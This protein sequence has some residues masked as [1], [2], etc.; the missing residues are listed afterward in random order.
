M[1][2]KERI[3]VLKDLKQLANKALESNKR[4]NNVVEGWMKSTVEKNIFSLKETI[5]DL[6]RD[7][8]PEKIKK[9][10]DFWNSYEEIQANTEDS[11]EFLSKFESLDQELLNQ[12]V[13][14][15]IQGDISRH[16][17]FTTIMYDLDGVIHGTVGELNEISFGIESPSVLSKYVPNAIRDLEE[18]FKKTTIEIFDISI[19][20]EVIEESLLLSQK[21]SYISSNLLILPVLE[22][23]CIDLIRFV[24]HKQNPNVAF[25]EI[26]N[27]LR[28]KYESVRKM[29]FKLKLD[30]DYPVTYISAISDY[31]FS[32]HP[33]IIEM[34]K[35]AR[36]HK[37]ANRE[38]KTL[39]ANL[40]SVLEN[41]E[42]NGRDENVIEEYYRVY[43][44]SIGS[45]KEKL[46]DLDK[47][48]YLP[49]NEKLNFVGRKIYDDRNRILHGQLDPSESS[50]KNYMYIIGL[51]KLIKIISEYQN[52]YK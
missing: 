7:L 15:A 20:K 31:S 49:L 24:Y 6:N 21:E 23:L 10:T 19:Y 40:P 51:N 13:P 45:I 44:K 27:I 43:N 36:L 46:L 25:D 1:N 12:V 22:G 37:K 4:F 5:K 39:L 50:W 48:K 33:T 8:K 47:P 11:S 14:F 16:T 28:D 26:K 18:T 29:I 34:L 38:F 2:A 9:Y 52:I 17:I 30:P 32:N 35:E 41:K 42:D 3:K